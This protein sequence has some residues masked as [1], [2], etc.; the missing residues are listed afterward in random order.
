M[1]QDRVMH[2]RLARI[3]HVD[4][5]RE[6][7]LVAESTDA[8]GEPSVMGVARMSKIHGKSDEARMSILIG[9]PY[10]GIGLGG[11]LIRRAVEVARSENIARMSAILTADNQVMI[12]IFKKLGFEIVPLAE[13]NLVAA[14]I[15]L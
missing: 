14:V 7:A 10:Q 15:Q 6:I 3:C 13:E 12:H 9:D 11:E 4:Y 8:A 2:E 5:D 1:L